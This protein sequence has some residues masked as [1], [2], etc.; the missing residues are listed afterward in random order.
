M[1]S[2]TIGSTLLL[3]AAGAAA[4]T[5][6]Q[7][8]T[9]QTS[10][11]TGTS[12][13]CYEVCIQEPCYACAHSCISERPLKAAS[14]TSI[15]TTPPSNAVPLPSP[16][17]VSVPPVS[18]PS[19]SDVSV[20][21]VSLPSPSDV[22]VP[23]VSLPVPSD[24]TF[25]DVTMTLP[26]ESLPSVGSEP[27]PTASITGSMSIPQGETPES[28][29]ASATSSRSG[30]ASASRSA[31]AEQTTAAAPPSLKGDSTSFML[32]LGVSGLSVLFGAAWALF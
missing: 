9:I 7:V 15:G 18:L 20:P 8:L 21:P 12:S 17:D 5:S 28:T 24:V 23:P 31:P 32:A 22:S 10:V 27:A 11:P 1:H 2:S 4:Q 19:P 29:G 13:V 6:E 30:S 14:L 16:I 3:L 25:E 26:V